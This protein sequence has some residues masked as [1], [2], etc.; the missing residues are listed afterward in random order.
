[1]RYI[2]SFLLASIAPAYADVPRV[3]TDLPPVHSLVSQVMGDLDAT[4]GRDRYVVVLTA[5]K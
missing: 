1:M 5:R 2:I 3:V 4:V